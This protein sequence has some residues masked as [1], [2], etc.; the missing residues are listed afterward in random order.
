MKRI[1]CLAAGL[2]VFGADARFLSV[3]PVK[4]DASTGGH[5]NRYAYAN[6]NPYKYVDPDGRVAIVTHHRNGDVSVHFPTRFHGPA[7]T[8]ERIDRIHAFVEAMSG[9]YRVNGTDTQVNFAITEIDGR[10]PRR[11]RN[12]VMLVEG[13]ERSNAEI[14]GRRAEIDVLDRFTANGVPAHEFSHLGGIDDLYDPIT[15]L[16]D[17]AHGDKIMNQVPGRVESTTVEGIINAR[18]NIRR[19]ER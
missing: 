16:P 17:P 5:F 18:T 8:Q 3:D 7:A 9:T 15:G 1:A 14:G 12:D 11:A 10:T 6:N 19:N 2:S 4:A 13:A